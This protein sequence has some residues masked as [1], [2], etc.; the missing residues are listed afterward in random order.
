[1]S[2]FNPH[3]SILNISRSNMKKWKELAEKPREDV[4]NELRIDV[5]KRRASLIQIGENSDDEV[6]KLDDVKH[7]DRISEETESAESVA[8]DG[9]TLSRSVDSESSRTFDN[10][11]HTGDDADTEDSQSERENT[12]S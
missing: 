3:L 12:G 7:Q 11:N 1:M 5:S 9:D 8:D 2:K 10:C 4:E 6:E